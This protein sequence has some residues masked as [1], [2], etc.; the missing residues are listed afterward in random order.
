MYP[1]YFIHLLN[2]SGTGGDYAVSAFAE[3]YSVSRGVKLCQENGGKYGNED[4]D[5]FMLDLETY[6]FSTE[7]D[8]TSAYNL[9]ITALDNS[10]DEDGANNKESFLLMGVYINAQEEAAQLLVVEDL[11]SGDDSN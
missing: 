2:V 5:D 7:K 1:K 6:F 4:E 10:M 3:E 11:E 8:R 9:A